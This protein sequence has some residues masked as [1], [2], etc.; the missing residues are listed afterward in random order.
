MSKLLDV[1]QGIRPEVDFSQSN[2]FLEDGMLDSFDMITLVADLD[3]AFGISIDGL[4]ILPENFHNLGAIEKLLV[5]YG[6]R[7]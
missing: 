1:L 7:P 2:D 5:R 4:D 3:N 6:V